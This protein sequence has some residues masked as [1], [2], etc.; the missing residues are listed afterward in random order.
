MADFLRIP[1]EALKDRIRVTLTGNS[2]AWVE[3]YQ[4][5]QEYSDRKVVL[6]GKGEQVCVEG[7]RLCMDYYTCDDMVIRGRIQKISVTESNR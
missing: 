5:I 3:N 6:L 7:E 2:R 1:P 4:S